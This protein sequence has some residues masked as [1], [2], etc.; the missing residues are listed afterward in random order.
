[1][2]VVLDLPEIRDRHAFNL[3]RWKEI[4][5]DPQLYKVEGRIE[6]DAHGHILMSPP[7]GFNHSERQSEIV[8]IL[9]QK[10]GGKAR[11]ECP[12]STTGGVRAVDA[13]WISLSR[14]QNAVRE[15]VLIVAPEI[16][17]EVLSPGNTRAEMEEKRALLFEAGAEEVWFCDLT[18]RMFFF[19]KEDPDAALATSRLCPDF[20]A[21][22]E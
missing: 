2:T 14:R 15:N 4:C 16:C 19:M 10:A 20:P 13:V 1:M 9:R 22:V 7:P 18:G 8:A 3:A 11:S 6:S 5:A 17:V 21:A 12:V